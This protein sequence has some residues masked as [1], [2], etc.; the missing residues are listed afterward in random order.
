[1]NGK[2]L[3][4]LKKRITIP[5]RKSSSPF[6]RKISKAFQNLVPLLLC[7]FAVWRGILYHQINARLSRI[8]AAGL[9]TSGAELNEWREP[10][11]E[12]E[13]GALVMTQA[14]SLIRI[15]DPH[16]KEVLKPELLRRTNEWSA[17]TRATVAEYVRTNAPAIAKARDVF[18]FS[19]FRYAVDFSFGPD[20]ELSHLD[21]LKELAR[22]VAL[23]AALEAEKGRPDEWPEHVEL[24]LRLATTLDDE[25]TIISHLVCNTIIRM[26]V[27]TTERSLNQAD[28]SDELCGKLQKAFTAVSRTNL[29][30]QALIGERALTIPTFRLSWSEIQSFDQGHDAGSQPRERHRYSG[31]PTLILWLPGIFERDLNFYLCTMEKSISLAALSFPESLG[32]TNHF[33]HAEEIAE[34]KLYFLAGMSF[35][36]ISKIAV[37]QASTRAQVNLAITALAL[38]RFRQ[39]RGQLPEALNALT[40]QFLHAVP[41]DPFDGAPLRYHRLAEGYVIYSIDVD[42]RDDG[43]REPPDRKKTTDKNSYDITFIV[44]R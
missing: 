32:L 19:Q 42:G 33:E 34:R 15:F 4:S 7:A 39:T 25:P 12:A 36:S 31:K 14:F 18:R 3:S 13:N 43:G 22:M 37:Q 9:P 17:E 24:L 44:G 28:P 26:A 20:T 30:P 41:T 21:Y 38:E 1:M 10:V 11:P 16:S 5:S 8:R 29:L 6:V 27:R 35:P 2:F 40:P 23:R